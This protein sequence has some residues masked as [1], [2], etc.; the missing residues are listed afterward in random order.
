MNEIDHEA[1][2]RE[3]AKAL[4][5][6]RLRRSVTGV[7]TGLGVNECWIALFLENERRYRKGGKP[8]PR[9]NDQLTAF[10]RAEFPHKDSAVYRQPAK[11]MWR[12][13]NARMY[14]GQKMPAPINRA[15]RYD[16]KGNRV[17]PRFF[18]PETD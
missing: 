18:D 17:H 6:K 10:M 11:A 4:I 12:Y 16:S 2:R 7:N 13:N 8:L 15:H 3:E 1:V 14:K 5:P 9:T